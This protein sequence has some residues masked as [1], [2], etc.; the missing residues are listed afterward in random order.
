MI[1]KGNNLS[2]EIKFC[3]V[4]RI[5]RYLSLSYEAARPSILGSLLGESHCAIEIR[6]CLCRS[7]VF[8]SSIWHTKGKPDNNEPIMLTMPH[9]L[10]QPKKI[11]TCF[12]LALLAHLLLVLGYSVVF[13]MSPPEPVEDTA[14]YLPAYVYHQPTTRAPQPSAS[15]SKPILKETPKAQIATQKVA[16]EAK[17]QNHRT[18]PQKT[19][20][21]EF[22]LPA[23]PTSQSANS[24]YSSAPNFVENKNVAKPLLKL[25]TQATAAHF[26]YPSIAQDFRMTGSVRIRFLLYPDGHLS[27]VSVVK[28]SG[29]GRY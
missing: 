8:F 6:M 23:S 22:D 15:H 5:R 26:T 7:G 20:A 17:P 24:P 25:L 1:S 12:W 21:Q 19:I 13:V 18:L 27:E 28:S 4:A 10:P 29:C 9:H 2:R 3:C 16:T 11:Q 14:I